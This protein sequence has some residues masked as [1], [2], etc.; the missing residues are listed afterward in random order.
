MK[1]KIKSFIYIIVVELYTLVIKRYEL[2]GHQ[3]PNFLWLE[4]YSSA[5]RVLILVL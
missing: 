4:R 2:G 3:C 5:A 1:K